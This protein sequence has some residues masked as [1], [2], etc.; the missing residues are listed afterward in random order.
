MWAIVQQEVNEQTPATSTAQLEAQ[1]KTAW[2]RIK[3]SVLESLVAGMS[4]RM[5][6]CVATE[7]GSIGK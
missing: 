7:G 6:D 2:G 5:R 1:V 4:Q 3:S